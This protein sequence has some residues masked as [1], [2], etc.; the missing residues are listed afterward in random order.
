MTREG[1]CSERLGQ[2]VAHWKGPVCLKMNLT[3]PKFLRNYKIVK[4]RIVG[5]PG[6]DVYELFSSPAKGP[7]KL[8]C[9]YVANIFQSVCEARKAYPKR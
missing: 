5:G 4:T 9:W 7:N 2:C 3:L 6:V 8:E 1:G